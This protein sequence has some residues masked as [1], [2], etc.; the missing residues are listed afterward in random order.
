MPFGLKMY[1]APRGFLPLNKGTTITPIYDV[2][3]EE[4]ET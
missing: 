3:N 2:F 1:Y 4:T